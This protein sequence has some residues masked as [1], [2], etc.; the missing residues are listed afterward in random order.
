VAVLSPSSSP[1]STPSSSAGSCRIDYQY[2]DWGT[3]FNGSVTVHNTGT[4]TINGWNLAFSFVGPQ[5]IYNALNTV[6]G[7]PLAPEQPADA[8][9]IDLLPAAGATDDTAQAV[10][11]L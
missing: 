6:W 4:A 3:T 5:S 10:I 2:T 1:S 7:G 8:L 9:L 11:R